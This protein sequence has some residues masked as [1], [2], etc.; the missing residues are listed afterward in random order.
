MHLRGPGGRGCSASSGQGSG[1]LPDCIRL[2]AR[3]RT[4]S[5]SP[6]ASR[7][8]TPLAPPPRGSSGCS[9]PLGCPGLL[10]S[11]FGY[12]TKLGLCKSTA[13]EHPGPGRNPSA[14]G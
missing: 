2:Q 14:G 4:T 8:S 6:W 3:L 7:W 13:Y 1:G 5:T 12:G 11:Y 10:D 9:H